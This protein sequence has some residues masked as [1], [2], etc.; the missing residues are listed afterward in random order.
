MQKVYQLFLLAI[1][2]CFMSI[3]CSKE[4]PAGPAGSQGPAGPTGPAGTNGTNGGTGPTGATGT[5]NVQY[6]DW[7][8]VGLASWTSI[9]NSQKQ[10]TLNAP[11]ITTAILDKGNVY[12]Y[13]RSQ[14]TTTVYIL[15]LTVVSNLHLT[16]TLDPGKITID[17]F[18]TVN[19]GVGI[20]NYE[21]RYVI[22]P[23]GTHVRQSQQAVDMKNYEAV[24]KYYGIPE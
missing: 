13:F 18:S 5:A 19:A 1:I 24:V 12:V 14:G 21:F 8:P 9:S 6:S 17:L 4:G 2:T 16:F 7:I 11:A 20:G 3:S 23:G 10:N 22:V 15:P